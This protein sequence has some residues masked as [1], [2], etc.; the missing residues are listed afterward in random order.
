MTA[1]EAV[2]ERGK[3]IIGMV[4]HGFVLWIGSLQNRAHH[5][6]QFGR[7]ELVGQ[8]AHP[9]QV[10]Q[11]GFDLPHQ[12]D[13]TRTLTSGRLAENHLTNSTPLVPRA[14]NSASKRSILLS[15]AASR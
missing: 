15:P 4:H 8:Y 1:K 5:A 13:A 12:S 2:F 3:F 14:E 7:S 11:T 10:T 9:G 6:G